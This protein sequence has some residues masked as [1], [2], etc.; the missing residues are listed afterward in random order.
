ML[1]RLSLK[2]KQYV[3]IKKF[4]IKRQDMSCRFGSKTTAYLRPKI[5]AVRIMQLLPEYIYHFS[6]L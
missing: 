5:S 2:I 1:Y 3:R 4:K 6:I